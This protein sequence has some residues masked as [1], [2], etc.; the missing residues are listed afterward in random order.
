MI[1]NAQL[2][3]NVSIMLSQV[4]TKMRVGDQTAAI[5]FLT[6]AVSELVQIVDA[7]EAQLQLLMHR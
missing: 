1:S 3:A 6:A 5:A 2:S 4:A 7:Q